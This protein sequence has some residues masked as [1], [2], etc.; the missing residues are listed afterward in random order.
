MAANHW[1]SRQFIVFTSFVLVGRII[2]RM[3]QD[4]DIDFLYYFG[5]MN[6]AEKHTVVRD[7]HA[8]KKIRVLVINTSSTHVPTDALS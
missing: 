5:S 1:P 2:G 6:N 3:L 7:F 4:E 8:N